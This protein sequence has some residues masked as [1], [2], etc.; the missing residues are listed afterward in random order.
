M[1]IAAFAFD[2]D[3]TI[4]EDGKVD[5]ATVA[6]LRRLKGAGR[7][8]LLVTGRELPDLQRAFPLFGE[9]DVIVAE[10]GALLYLPSTAE[11]RPLGAPPPIRWP[12]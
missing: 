5:E 1:L 4:A 8:I 3:G 12:C 7:K 2:Y 9:F 11:E 10:N 6:A